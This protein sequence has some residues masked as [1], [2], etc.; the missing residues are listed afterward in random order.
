M[1]NSDVRNNK[2]ETLKK[3]KRLDRPK[4]KDAAK[5]NTISVH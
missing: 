5:I 4:I 1:G 2:D 3:G